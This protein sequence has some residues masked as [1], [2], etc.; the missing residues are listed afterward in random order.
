MRPGTFRDRG[1]CFMV[2]CENLRKEIEEV[3]AGLDLLVKNGANW[4]EIYKAS[5][6]LDKLVNMEMNIK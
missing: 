4:D 2:S 3:R 1:L 6:I 5:V